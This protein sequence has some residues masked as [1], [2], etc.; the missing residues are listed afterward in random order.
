MPTNIDFSVFQWNCRS[1]YTNQ[2]Q[3]VQHLAGHDYQVLTLQSLNVKKDKLPRLKN[4]YFPPIH[5]KVDT[6]EKINVA[7]YVREGVDYIYCPSPVPPDT[8]SIYSCATTIRFNSLNLMVMS[9]Y[10]PLGPNEQNTEWI[11]SLQ[12]DLSK[13]ILITGDFNAHAPFW[14]K[15][16]VSVTSNRFI[17]NVVDSSFYLLNDGSITRIPDNSSH[18]A[19]AIDLTMVSPDLAP[20]C[21]WKTLD[22]PLNSDHLPIITCFNNVKPMPSDQTENKIPKFNYKLADWDKFSLSLSTFHIDDIDDKSIDN[23]YTIFTTSVISAASEAIPKIK[24]V[25]SKKHT[26]NIWWNEACEEAK[27]EKKSKFKTYLKEKSY[28]NHIEMKKAKNKA[29]MIMA[30]A[31]RLYWSSFCKNEV[32][33]HKDMQKVW[34]K[35]KTMKNGV[36]LPEC[37]IKVDKLDT[38]SN[39]DKAETFVEM[40]SFYS[41]NSGLSEK[42]KKLREN[43]DKLTPPKYNNHTGNHHINAP[44]SI[45]EVEECIS[46]LSNKKTSVGLDGI[47]NEMLRHLPTNVVTFL[48][49]FM[50]K[51]WKEGNIPLVWKHS[52]VVPIY[53]QG[54]PRSDKDSYR[55]IALTSHPCKVMEKIILN[56]LI[57]H[58]EKY[59]ILPLNQAGF[60]KGRSTNDHLV[61]LTTHVKQQ[62]ARRKNVLATFFDVRK[63]Y[64]QVWHN[65]LLRKLEKFGVTGSMYNYISNFLADRNIQ[66]RIGNSYSK[67][68]LLQMGLPQGSVISPILFNILI[69]D[70]PLGLS[71]DTILAQFA[72]DICLWMKVTMKRKTPKRALNY[73]KKVYQRELDK[74]SNYMLENGLSLSLEK[75]HIMLFNSGLDPENLPK[76]TIDG[77]VIKYTQMVK[78]LGVYLTSKLTW[79]YHIE[80]ILNKARKSLNFLKIV[81]KQYWGQDTKTLISLASSLVRSRLTYAQEVFFS[82]PSYLLKKLQSI[83]SKAYKLALGVPTHAW[84]LGTYRE[85]GV[86]PLDEQRKASAANLVTKNDAY[87]TFTKNEVKFTLEK[88]F[89]K[90]AK[91]IQSLK[92]INT[93]ASQILDNTGLNHQKIAPKPP[94][95]LIPSW[96]QTKP[97]FDIDHSTL[98]TKK[99]L[100]TY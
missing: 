42:S 49:L 7:I 53:K 69:A 59:K 97:N 95:S 13:N 70:L 80:Y 88:D 29:N 27:K 91:T 37:P 55:P 54:K 67:P 9:V 17:E 34:E 36:K 33:N 79:N 41:C 81:S 16:C 89:V 68:R 57:H 24:S 15:D 5:Q 22:D 18:K 64:D 35:L 71:K 94:F 74:I 43:E 48:H 63:A 92:P 66:V 2:D 38:P 85:S 96:E 87:E 73:T 83:D 8:P 100:L 25:K 20:I 78:F 98:T 1:I 28:F 58:C 40:F 99:T 6:T 56:R 45:H 30:Q 75:T 84:V 76:F 4:Y 86:L 90:R 3:L 65:R 52:I 47:S 32:Y 12:S 62:F 39:Q 50:S 72:D 51:C 31:K 44:I 21:N 14:E 26:G 46:N 60:R 93:F 77:A 10:L 61:K 82:A 19:S 23:L 11:R